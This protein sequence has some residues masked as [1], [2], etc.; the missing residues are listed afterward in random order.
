MHLNDG[1]ATFVG[2]FNKVA[3]T[4]DGRK[5]TFGFKAPRGEQFAVLLLGSAPKDAEDFD[6]EAALNRLGFFRREPQP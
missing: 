1:D 6:I 5:V 2:S 4:E 3:W